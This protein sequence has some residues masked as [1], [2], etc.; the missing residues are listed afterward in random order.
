MSVNGFNK[1][2]ILAALLVPMHAW[3]TLGGNAD[4]VIADK[5]ALPATMQSTAMPRYTVS[6]LKLPSGTVVREYADSITGTVFGLS[7]QGPVIPN[8]KQILGTYFDAYLKAIPSGIGPVNVVTP[9]LVVRSSGH[10]RAFWGQ[11]YLPSIL[12]TGVPPSD[13]Q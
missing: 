12:P 3:A 13:I 11:A 8:L 1:F 2:P 6:E 10:M 4:S 9:N 5:T 7:W